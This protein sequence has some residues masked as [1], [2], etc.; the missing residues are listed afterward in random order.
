[1]HAHPSG[2]TNGNVPELHPVHV[3]ALGQASGRIAQ[4]IDARTFN[5]HIH[6]TMALVPHGRTTHFGKPSWYKP[7]SLQHADVQKSGPFERL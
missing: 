7:Y 6:P 1:M 2:L 3:M 5:V 4:N